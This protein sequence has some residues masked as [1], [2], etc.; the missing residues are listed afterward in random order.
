[1]L[2]KPSTSGVGQHLERP[3]FPGNMYAV[4]LVVIPV[5]STEGR[6]NHQAARRLSLSQPRAGVSPALLT[7]PGHV[8][9]PAGSGG[10]LR[11]LRWRTAG[12]ARRAASNATSATCSCHS[13]TGSTTRLRCPPGVSPR[14]STGSPR[15]PR[16][17][18]D[19]A[20]AGGLRSSVGVGV[21]CAPT[22]NLI[23]CRPARGA[24]RCPT[25]AG[26]A[27][28]VQREDRD[29]DGRKHLGRYVAEFAGHFN[30]RPRDTL[31][32]MAEMAHGPIGGRLCYR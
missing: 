31:D 20:A 30:D 11:L 23:T 3:W 17:Q 5:F 29:R 8:G 22:A 2:S 1:M 26:R 27:A 13:A 16:S 12:T 6:L 9:A 14:R 19:Q 4:H 7:A 10:G 21:R 15:C 18:F 24:L 25:A 28:T 32:Q